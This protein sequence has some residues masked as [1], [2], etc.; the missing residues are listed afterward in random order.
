MYFMFFLFI[1]TS[2]LYLATYYQEQVKEMLMSLS[3]KALCFKT[4]LE[5]YYE[6]Y[7]KKEEDEKEI[8]RIIINSKNLDTEII[9][10]TD[11][12]HLEELFPMIKRVEQLQENK[13]TLFYYKNNK[14]EYYIRICK[15]TDFDELTNPVFVDNPFFN[16]EVEL[17][18]DNSENECESSEKTDITSKLKPFYVKGNLLFDES[19]MSWFMKE[20]FNI[21]LTKKYKISVLKEDFE[22]LIFDQSDELTKNIVL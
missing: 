12:S 14:E 11:S 20:F 8:R 3:W 5:S 2:S 22:N 17:I 16:V 15:N 7:F 4:K 21:K 13:L 6:K 1:C 9:E 19:F 10:I 18:C